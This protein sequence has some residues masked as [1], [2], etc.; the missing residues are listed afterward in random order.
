MRFIVDH[1]LPPALA[2]WLTARGHEAQHV[3]L[4]GLGEADD[5]DIW[6]VALE[7]NAVVITKDSDFAKRRGWVSE[8]PIIAWLRVGNSATP[9]LLVWLERRWE[10]IEAAILDGVTVIEVR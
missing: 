2:C 6:R 7:Q 8:G 3:F 5:A 10:R 4:M 9:D 1:Q